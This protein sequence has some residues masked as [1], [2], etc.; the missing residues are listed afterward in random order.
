M[1][2]LLIALIDINRLDQQNA[3]K[4]PFLLR[5][6]QSVVLFFGCCCC[7]TKILHLFDGW[8]YK[9]YNLH[10]CQEQRRPLFSHWMHFQ[11]IPFLLYEQSS[12]PLCNAQTK[13]L[14]STCSIESF[15]DRFG[16]SCG[17]Q[18]NFQCRRDSLL[19]LD[20]DDD[21]LPSKTLSAVLE[22]R[23]VWREYA[24]DA[25]AA[26]FTGYSYGITFHPLGWLYYYATFL[27]LRAQVFPGWL[28]ESHWMWFTRTTAGAPHSKFLAFHRS[29]T[30]FLSTL[31]LRRRRSQAAVVVVAVAFLDIIACSM[32][33]PR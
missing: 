16:R 1:H 14:R 10:F 20:G 5:L 3:I 2:S 27:H 21:M 32:S 11:E 12:S 6:S 8:L 31:D 4:I 30:L 15:L 28:S 29:V 23:S 33:W 18:K 7:T 13:K 26:P 25:A 17:L 24:E 19:W 22:Y 9:I